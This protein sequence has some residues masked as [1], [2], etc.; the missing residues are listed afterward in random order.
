MVKHASIRLLLAII[1]YGDLQLEQLD[2]KIIFLYGELEERIY[3][4]QPEGFVQEGQKTRRV[5]S[6]SPFMG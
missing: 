4:K 2:V 3:M 5:F 6:I 1:A